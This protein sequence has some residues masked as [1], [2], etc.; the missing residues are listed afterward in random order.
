MLLH[1]WKSLGM[2]P[3]VV[4]LAPLAAARESLSTC[5]MGIPVGCPLATIPPCRVER[6]PWPAVAWSEVVDPDDGG[7]A[8]GL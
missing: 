5:T 8:V 6:E 7:M 4:R 3:L 1:T 2:P